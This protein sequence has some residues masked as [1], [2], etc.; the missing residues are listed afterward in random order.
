MS[1]YVM[2]KGD[3]LLCIGTLEEIAMERGVQKETM[4]YYTTPAYQ[5]K[6]AKRKNPRNYITLT[7]LD[8]EDE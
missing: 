8:D 5:R 4:H 7:R 6:L 2:Y 3:D 1:E